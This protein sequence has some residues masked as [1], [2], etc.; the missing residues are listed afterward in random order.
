MKRL[1]L[2]L[3]LFAAA[4]ACLLVL[5]ACAPSKASVTFKLDETESIVITVN[6]DKKAFP[7]Y[8]ECAEGVYVEG[9]Y[10]DSGLTIKFDFSQTV[11]D[12]ITLYPSI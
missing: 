5:C 10:V 4:A 6:D 2:L 8:V 3:L 9:W 7:P 12:D 1:R 11:E